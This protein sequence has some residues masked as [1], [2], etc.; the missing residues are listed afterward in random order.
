MCVDV[1]LRLMSLV[2]VCVCLRLRTSIAPH[3]EQ[4]LRAEEER[5]QVALLELH[6]APVIPT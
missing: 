4:R 1:W 5:L 2:C 3:V 6:H